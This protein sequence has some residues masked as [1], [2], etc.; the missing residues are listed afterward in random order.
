LKVGRWTF[1]VGLFLFRPEAAFLSGGSQI[2]DSTE[3]LCEIV[4]QL[5]W[6]SIRITDY[7]LYY[8]FHKDLACWLLQ[9]D[10]HEPRSMLLARCRFHSAAEQSRCLRQGSQAQF[11]IR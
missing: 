7:G 1:G 8:N 9:I 4:S 6:Q 3:Q 5:I 2:R 11:V 10:V